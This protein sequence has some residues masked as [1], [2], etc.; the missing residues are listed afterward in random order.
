MTDDNLALDL[1]LEH[2]RIS[3]KDYIILKKHQSTRPIIIDT[4]PSIIDEHKA[5]IERNLGANPH[6]TR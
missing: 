1:M 6:L 2:G 3:Y 5:N 4:S